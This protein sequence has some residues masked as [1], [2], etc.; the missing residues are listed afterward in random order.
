MK[1]FTFLQ[2][3]RE[4]M[5][6]EDLTVVEPVDSVEVRLEQVDT[7]D[8]VVVHLTFVKADQHLLIV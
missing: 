4:L 3:V 5:V 8:Q 7:P 1:H 2:V 6:P